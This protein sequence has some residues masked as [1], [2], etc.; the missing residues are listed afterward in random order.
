MLHL[1]RECYN[2]ID[3]F[4]VEC[5]SLCF[6][7]RE[8]NFYCILHLYSVKSAGEKNGSATKSVLTQH[9]ATSRS[10]ERNDIHRC[11]YRTDICGPLSI[12]AKDEL[13]LAELSL[14]STICV[15][16]LMLGNQQ[17]LVIRIPPQSFLISATLSTTYFAT[18][19]NFAGLL[20]SM[21]HQT[22]RHLQI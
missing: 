22:L 18:V 5:I 11:I 12:T 6:V 16:H 20:E 19:Q 3:L 15:A 8:R 1:S 7:R 17:V 14:K 9:A 21:K 13:M 4:L 2:W 10:M